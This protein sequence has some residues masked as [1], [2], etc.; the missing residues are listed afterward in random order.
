VVNSTSVLPLGQQQ[1]NSHAAA[2]RF[3]HWS[4]IQGKNDVTSSLSNCHNLTC[5]T[6]AGDQHLQ[7]VTTTLT[8]HN[9]SMQD[10]QEYGKR[11]QNFTASCEAVLMHAQHKQQRHVA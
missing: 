2:H 4:V 10:N 6:A 3:V 11:Q 1:R 9:F 7:Q 5:R 8:N